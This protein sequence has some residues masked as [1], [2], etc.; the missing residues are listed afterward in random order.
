MDGFKTWKQDVFGGEVYFL[1]SPD[2]ADGYHSDPGSWLQTWGDVVDGVFTW[3]SGWPSGG[4]EVA[5]VT[6]T[7]D[8][9]VQS[10]AHDSSKTY[11]ARRLLCDT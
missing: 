10:A 6:D 1:P 5:N 7:F 8:K 2:D 4:S 11:M 3:E 9:E